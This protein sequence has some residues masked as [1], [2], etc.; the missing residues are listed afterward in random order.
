MAERPRLDPDAEWT[1]LERA[2]VRVLMPGDAEYPARLREIHSAP[3]LLYIRGALMAGDD[4]ALAVVGTRR[5]TP[6][7]RAVTERLVADLVA[8][9]LTIV[10]GL[11]R[12]MDAV[13]HRTALEAEGRTIAVLGSGLDII[14]PGEHRALA[15]RIAERGALLSDYPLGTQPDATNFPA[16]NRIISGLSR[17][18]L[19][20]EAPLASGARITVNYAVEQSR[21]VFA[22]PGSILSAASAT[23]NQLC[24][25][26]HN[27]AIG[28]V[29]S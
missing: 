28:S 7:G 24:G 22:V 23:P 27:I 12:G 15:A 26:G 14:Y 9:G 20:T 11:A 18:V 21:E 10:S 6:Y 5:A 17:G 3:P 16:R 2:G 4:L 8:A 29:G 13:A 1:G 19:I 25:R